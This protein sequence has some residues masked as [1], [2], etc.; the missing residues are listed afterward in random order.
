A[1]L[2]GLAP[3]QAGWPEGGYAGD[4]I[5]D[6][7]ADFRAGKTVK[8]DDRGVTASGDVDDLDAIREFAVAYLRHEQD[9]D[10]A[11]F[12]LHFDHYYLESSLYESGRV[13]STVAR[14][15]AGGQTYE[16][17]GALWLRTT[18]YGDDKDRVMRKSDGS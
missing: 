6:I 13:A 16:E 1:R 5:A 2:D 17:G 15:V 8:A 14:I 18:A 11:A 3:G 12:G 7:A 9:L 4:Y 10:L